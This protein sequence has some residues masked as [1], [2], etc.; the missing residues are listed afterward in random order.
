LYERVGIEEDDE[1]ARG[2]INLEF[3]CGYSVVKELIP[4]V[5]HEPDS[6]SYTTGG[7]GPLGNRTSLLSW[8]FVT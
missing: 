4:E 2:G 5:E 8:A 7:D 6:G 3:G 1:D